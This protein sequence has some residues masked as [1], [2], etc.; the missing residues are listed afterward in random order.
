MRAA[1]RADAA[2]ADADR[3]DLRAKADAEL[4]AAREAAARPHTCHV[5]NQG[6]CHTCGV[7]IDPEAWHAYAGEPHEDV[8]L[9]RA[10][11]DLRVRAELRS[12]RSAVRV[13]TA[14]LESARI[15][16]EA[17]KAELDSART[18]LAVRDENLVAASRPLAEILADRDAAARRGDL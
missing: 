1:L 12:A 10:G 5:D 9:L 15:A 14:D 6:V 11:I 17:A 7:L 16:A 18:L 3:A 13:A 4:F 8:P 2:E